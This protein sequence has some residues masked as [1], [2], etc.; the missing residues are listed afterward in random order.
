MITGRGGRLIRGRSQGERLDIM[1]TITKWGISLPADLAS[2]P[3]AETL[4]DHVRT[5]R[6][7]IAF[8][9]YLRS[10]RMS[11]HPDDSYF[12]TGD[13][14][15]ALGFSRDLAGVQLVGSSMTEAEAK[16]L[17]RLMDETH[18]AVGRNCIYS[19]HMALDEIRPMR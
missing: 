4:P 8:Y 7:A 15:H 1:P 3:E 12:L 11:M 19:L 18:E 9:L 6:D 17:D 13:Q 16:N 10:R 5:L 14:L 2:I